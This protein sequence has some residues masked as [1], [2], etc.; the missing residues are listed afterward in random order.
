LFA[1]DC[2]DPS[3]K[4]L[5]IHH[6]VSDALDWCTTFHTNFVIVCD[7]EKWLGVINE[8]ILFDLDEKKKLK[9]LESL[10][11]PYHLSAH[12][13]IFD[14]LK[15]TQLYRSFILPV[16]DAEFMLK[17]ITSAAATLEAWSKDAH[18]TGAGGILILELLPNDYSLAEIAKIAESNNASILHSMIS[19]APNPDKIRVSLKINKN[20]LKDIQSTFERYNY[21]VVAVIH[22]SE[23]EMELQDRL[24]SLMKYLEV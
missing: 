22:Q 3:I 23:F 9:D 13:H 15:S 6:T 11:Q 18:F 24:D 1:P 2:I 17:G 8:E 16:V 20:D 4:P 10:L 19:T 21:E 12:T 5:Q 14:V 7:G